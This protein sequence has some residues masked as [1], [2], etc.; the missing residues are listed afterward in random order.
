M[1]HKDL[2]ELN[3]WLAADLTVNG[4]RA[5]KVAATLGMYHRTLA[6]K[7]AKY[8]KV[9]LAERNTT[10]LALT[11]K[12]LSTPLIAHAFQMTRALVGEI[13][14]GAG[15]GPGSGGP[16]LKRPP[17]TSSKNARNHQIRQEHK[18]MAGCRG[19]DSCLA[20]KHGVSRQ[21]I[22]QIVRESGFGGLPKEAA[23]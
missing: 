4:I 18:G 13:I 21:R 22:F 14:R 5:P 7:L 10:I 1:A 17:R 9:L 20:Q 12:G 23:K 2:S 16:K 11:D 8:R 15:R 3:L 19:R 6:P